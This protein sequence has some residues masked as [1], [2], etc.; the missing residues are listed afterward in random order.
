MQSPDCAGLTTYGKG[1]P[2]NQSPPPSNTTGKRNPNL[3]RRGFAQ[4]LS[5]RMRNLNSSNW[6]F[7]GPS[8]SLLVFLGFEILH[9]GFR[10]AVHVQLEVYPAD[11]SSHG[12]DMDVHVIGNFLV[13]ATL[14]EELENLRFLGG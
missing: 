13:G 4:Q 6:L 10:A 7:P 12:L 2:C 9:C 14:R 1:R 8:R 3:P 11:M 5:Q